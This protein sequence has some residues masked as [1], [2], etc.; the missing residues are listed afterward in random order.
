MEE[1][2][3]FVNVKQ[4]NEGKLELAGQIGKYTFLNIRKILKL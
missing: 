3:F 4:K 1:N 2:L